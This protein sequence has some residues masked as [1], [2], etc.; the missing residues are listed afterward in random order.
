MDLLLHFHWWKLK[1]RLAFALIYYFYNSGILFQ[2]LR[3]DVMTPILQMLHHRFGNDSRT[4][5]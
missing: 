4:L 2:H 3:L 5:A 1:V